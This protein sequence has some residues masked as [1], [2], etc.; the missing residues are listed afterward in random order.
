[1]APICGNTHKGPEPDGLG[2]EGN[3]NTNAGNGRGDGR[4][5]KHIKPWR[6]GNRREKSVTAKKKEMVGFAA[7]YVLHTLLHEYLRS[8]AYPGD[9]LPPLV[10]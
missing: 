5:Y 8:R 3:L 1:M 10:P 2:E 7:E 4:I 6:T 9:C